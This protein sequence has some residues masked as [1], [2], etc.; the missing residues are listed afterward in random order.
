MYFL[1]TNGEVF[2]LFQEFHAIVERETKKKL[3]CLCTDNGG[4]YT[5]NAFEAYCAS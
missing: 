4:E 1:K 5:S 2:Q 3:K